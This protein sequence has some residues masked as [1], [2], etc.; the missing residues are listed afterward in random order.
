MIRLTFLLLLAVNATAAFG[1]KKPV[2]AYVFNQAFP[3]SVRALSLLALDGSTTTFGEVLDQ[4][5]GKR[6]MIDIWAS[7]CRDCI[8]ALPQLT[9][10]HESANSDEVV[11]LALSLD[12]EEGKWRTA[13]DRLNIKGVHYWIPEGWKNPFSN[14]IVLDWIPRYLVLD[15]EGRVVLP[16]AIHADN[17]AL[18]SEVMG[19]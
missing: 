19:K 12:R 6:I 2:P 9:K 15:K 3:D 4:H 7:W 14:Y 10:I 17:P 18:L 16:K 11:I 13:I 8:V 5:R 1:Q